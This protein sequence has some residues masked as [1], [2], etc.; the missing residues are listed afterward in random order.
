MR[1]GKGERE[2]E[3]KREGCLTWMTSAGASAEFLF[4]PPSIE[5]LGSGGVGGKSAGGRLWMSIFSY[6][7]M[8]FFSL[9]PYLPKG[10]DNFEKIKIENAKLE[11]KAERQSKY[12]ADLES[13]QNAAD[14]KIRQ[15]QRCV[16]FWE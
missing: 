11:A 13:R 2:R 4:D 9:S 6:L 15:L 16:G 10:E 14:T 5:A 3:K 1:Q 7:L 12:R 8:F